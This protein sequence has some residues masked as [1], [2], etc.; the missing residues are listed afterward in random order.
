[1]KDFDAQIS[2]QIYSLIL[3]TNVAERFYVTHTHTILLDLDF[4]ILIKYIGT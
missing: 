1:M 3:K 2:I 4:S